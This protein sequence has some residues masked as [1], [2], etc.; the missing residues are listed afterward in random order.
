M[1]K[2]DT[3]GQQHNHVRVT[4][5]AT[6]PAATKTASR[7]DALKE[8]PSTKNRFSSLHGRETTGTTVATLNVQRNVSSQQQ[9]WRSRAATAATTRYRQQGGGGGGAFCSVPCAVGKQKKDCRSTGLLQG[10]KFA[11]FKRL[12]ESCRVVNSGKA[13]G[14]EE[15]LC[16]CSNNISNLAKFIVSNNSIL[17]SDGDPQVKENS[18][19]SF[20]SA[21]E[22][23]HSVVGEIF[24]S[25]LEKQEFLLSTKHDRTAT[26]SGEKDLD[27]ALLDVMN[28]ILGLLKNDK[29][30]SSDTSS[31]PTMSFVRGQGCTDLKD[32]N[33]NKML[34]SSY[35][36]YA[37]MAPLVDDVTSE[38]SEVLV[39]NPLRK[40][41]LSALS[42]Q[43][44]R[45]RHQL[46]STSD[47]VS[48][49]KFH[50]L[51]RTCECLIAALN[52]AKDIEGTKRHG[53]AT[54]SSTKYFSM[55]VDQ[56]TIYRFV[57]FACEDYEKATIRR[58]EANITAAD[59]FSDGGRASN[60]LLPSSLKYH[61]LQLLRALLWRHPESSSYFATA[62][63]YWWLAMKVVCLTCSSCCAFVPAMKADPIARQATNYKVM[64]ARLLVMF[65]MSS[66]TRQLIMICCSIFVR[67]CIESCLCY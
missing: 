50:L 57:V 55:D 39:P 3:T 1:S 64:H 45:Q 41:L 34:A 44:D 6:L 56:A 14:T 62:L 11:E 27:M 19:P 61:A 16:C 37:M 36:S 58:R 18:K 43:M 9:P 52:L 24:L 63:K 26:T 35:V 48:D 22:I 59:T 65:A 30:E 4:T 10:N 47:K 15:S 12:I 5:K 2:K 60:T 21:E 33:N 53:S 51:K 38:G 31:A 17:C 40:R 42:L 32:N 67:M 49:I 13:L 54:A 20:I 46:Q 8:E 66:C 7:W 29:R 25:F 23:A 28:S